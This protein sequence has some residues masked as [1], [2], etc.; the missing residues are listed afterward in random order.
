M[1]DRVKKVTYC[2]VRVPNRAGQGQ[3]VMGKLRE[4]GVNLLAYSGFPTKGGKAQLDFIPED[5]VA[6]RRVARKNGWRLSKAKKGFLITGQD[7]LGAVDRHIGK[8]ADAKIS[9]TAAD[10]VVAGK[11][12]Y[13][14]ILWVKPKDY[15]RAA[16]ALGAK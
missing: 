5:V 11:G 2:Y 3:K 1:A 15:A 4:E 16:R 14:M 7:R 8:L 13:G 9:V 6:L 10:A 12:R